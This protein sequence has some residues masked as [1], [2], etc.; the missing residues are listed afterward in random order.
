MPLA[1]SEKTPPISIRRLASLTGASRSTISRAFRDGASVSPRL[2]AR[3]LAEAERHG[4]RPDPL[5]SELMTSFARRKP[6]DYRETLGV[7]WW[8]ERWEQSQVSRAFAQRLRAGLEAAVEKHG[9]RLTPFV[10]QR[11]GAPALMRT[12]KARNIQGL[13]VTPPTHPNQEAPGLDWSCLSTVVIGRSLLAPGFDRV[14]H[15]H[16][17]SMVETLAALRERGLTRPVLLAEVSLEERMLRAYTGAF[18]AH[19][20]VA[21]EQ[22]LHLASRDPAV[23]ARR[24]KGLSFDVIIADVEE[25]ID[26]VKAL[27][28]GLRARGFVALDLKRRDGAI[29]G[30]YQNVERM[31]ACAVDLL[32]Q[33]RLHNERGVPPEPIS[34]LTPGTWIE[35]ETFR[36]GAGAVGRGAKSA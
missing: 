1:P 15:N 30:I 18:L 17:A 11:G 21:Q 13:V 6:V 27:P 8:P 25:W 2:R 35:G 22:V 32:M 23:L 28:E 9:C 5:V 4:Y 14:H 34:M 10:L 31:A 3:I 20:G 29:S 24:L 26:A 33:R 19:G 16:Y 7:L 36:L 12:F